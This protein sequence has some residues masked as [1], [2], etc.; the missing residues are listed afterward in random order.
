MACVI[1]CHFDHKAEVK[2]ILNPK[3]TVSQKVIFNTLEEINTNIGL[4][5]TDE[6]KPIGITTP[7][8]V[9]WEE[10]KWKDRDPNYGISPTGK[11]FSIVIDK[12]L[13]CN[14]SGLNIEVSFTFT[15]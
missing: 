4:A 11:F 13:K 6:I 5:T 15:N 12:T 3:L 14:K 2:P 10:C 8:R 1:K 7:F 9:F